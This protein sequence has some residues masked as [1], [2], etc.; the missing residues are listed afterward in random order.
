MGNCTGLESITLYSKLFHVKFNKIT[1]LQYP[2]K[3]PCKIIKREKKGRERER[4]R[5]RMKKRENER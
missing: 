3:R 1:F 4:E 5:E 2:V